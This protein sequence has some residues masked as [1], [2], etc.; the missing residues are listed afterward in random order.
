M[1]LLEYALL[2]PKTFLVSG[3]AGYW[4]K[5]PDQMQANYQG[6]K[7]QVTNWQ[8][9]NIFK[10]ILGKLAETGE[11]SQSRKNAACTVLWPLAHWVAKN[12]IGEASEIVNWIYELNPGFKIPEGGAL[13]LMYNKL[14]FK[15]TEKILAARRILKHG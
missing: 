2:N 15:T 1:F 9:L 5:H 3:N 14:G 8:H 7:S 4:V 6:L 12:H 11:L 10:K 13:G